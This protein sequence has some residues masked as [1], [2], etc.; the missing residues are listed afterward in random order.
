MSKLKHYC[1][2]NLTEMK[3]LLSH[4]ESIILKLAKVGLNGNILN[5]NSCSSKNVPWKCEREPRSLSI[6][7]WIADFSKLWVEVKLKPLR[8]SKSKKR[9]GFVGFKSFRLWSKQAYLRQSS[10]LSQRHQIDLVSWKNCPQ[11]LFSKFF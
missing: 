3:E 11:K 9:L 1:K 6:E 4:R 7:T 2:Q 10:L 8:I 5:Q